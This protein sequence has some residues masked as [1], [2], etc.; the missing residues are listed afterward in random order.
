MKRRRTRTWWDS[1]DATGESTSDDDIHEIG[2]HYTRADSPFVEE[3]THKRRHIDPGLG[4]PLS[5]LT[6]NEHRAPPYVTELNE[7][8]MPSGGSYEISPDRIYV[9]TL[10]DS[11]EEDKPR[12]YELNPFVAEKLRSSAA[13]DSQLPSMKPAEN[14]QALILWRPNEL[15]LPAEPHDDADDE[16]ESAGAMDIE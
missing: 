1:G 14:S 15:P 4:Q 13:M 6:L 12:D 9:H 3:G 8:E 10:D 11:D 5:S 2:D 7:D 16:V